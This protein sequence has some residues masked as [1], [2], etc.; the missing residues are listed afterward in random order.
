MD[1]CIGCHTCAF[2][3]AYA[4]LQLE[5]LLHYSAVKVFHIRCVTTGGRGR[6]TLLSF[7]KSKK[8]PGFG[9]K[10]P[11]FVHPEVKFTI[12]NIVLRVS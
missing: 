9:K 11:D 10:G 5:V 6:P 3:V 7:W 1:Q 2:T 4:I 12:Q 8:C